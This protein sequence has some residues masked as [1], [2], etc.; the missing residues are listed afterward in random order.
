MTILNKEPP[1]LIEARKS[2]GLREIPGAATA[3]TIKRWLRELGAWWSDDATPWCGTA[4]AAW[5]RADG[6]LLPKH[7]YRARAW[8]DWG[9]HLAGPVVGCV[10]VLQREGG[11]HVGLVVGKDMAGN[12]AVLGGNQGDRVSIAMFPRNRVLGYRWPLG[13]PQSFYAPPVLTAGQLSE[14]EA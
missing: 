5:M 9:V 6:Q 11:G 3:G 2:L 4:V 7:W 10:V 8:L 13:E 14:S 12:I 1:W